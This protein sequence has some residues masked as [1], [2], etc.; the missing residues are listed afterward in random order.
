M[1]TAIVAVAVIGFM[2]AWLGLVL[3]DS[4]PRRW[5]PKRLRRLYYKD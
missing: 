5:V 2:V 4:L 1:I 3:V